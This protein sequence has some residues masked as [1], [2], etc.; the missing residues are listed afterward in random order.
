MEL[1]QLNGFALWI[2]GAFQGLD[3]YLLSFYHSLAQNW[4][5]V[6]TPILRLITLTGEDGLFL[7]AVSFLMMAFPKTRK[8]G[9]CTLLAIAVGAVFTNVLIK[10]IVFR[11]RPYVYRADYREW[12]TYVGAIVESDRSFPSGHTTAAAAFSTAFVYIRGKKFLPWAVVYVLLM[13]IS[14]NY[15]I[16][17]YPSD[18]IVGTVV[19][20]CGGTI[21]F[22][23]LS[24]FW[25]RLPEKWTRGC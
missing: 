19:G 20:F 21:A 5:A 18:V 17:H 10:H 22:L 6:L 7:I 2:T 15:L 9:A 4:G 1:M 24:R 11:P 12:W 16:V 13:A 25:S 14:R 8:T 23:L 3:Y